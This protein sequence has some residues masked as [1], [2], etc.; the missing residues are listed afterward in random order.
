MIFPLKILE[1]QIPL[2]I[3]IIGK[4]FIIFINGNVSLDALLD[5]TVISYN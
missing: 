2:R 4:Q 1:S 3:P 5:I